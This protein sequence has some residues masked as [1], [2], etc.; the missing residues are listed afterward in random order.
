MS[1]TN[2]VVE[3]EERVTDTVDI[4]G[5][6]SMD[7][8]ENVP[9][10]TPKKRPTAAESLA[11][12]RAADAA[13]KGKP[14]L[15]AAI[16]AGVPL[17][18]ATTVITPKPTKEPKV[19][20]SKKP[21][22]KTPAKSNETSPKGAKKKE[23][24]ELRTMQLRAL[25]ALEAASATD[26]ANGLSLEQLAKKANISTQV[27]KRG[28]GA[29][30]VENREAHDAREG[31]KS[32]LSRGMVKIGYDEERGNV[33]FLGA[34]GEKATEKNGETLATLGKPHAKPF[35]KNGETKKKPVKKSKKAVTVS[36]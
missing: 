25:K 16:N 28:L 10:A 24:T 36:K 6:F 35:S 5:G 34:L 1:E 21:V 33:Y 2:Q 7:V 8:V 27:M 32:L 9:V 26:A 22:K 18:D 31:F 12:Q 11:K 13:K 29:A 23:P 30:K 4:G 3:T 17:D 19:K 20:A 14:K 15:A